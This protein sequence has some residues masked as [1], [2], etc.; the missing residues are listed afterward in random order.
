MERPVPRNDHRVFHR[1]IRLFD[2]IDAETTAFLAAAGA[3]VSLLLSP[4]GKVL[5]VAYRD[6]ALQRYKPDGWIGKPFRDTVTP[7]CH[8]KIDALIEETARAGSTRR[9]Q[10]NHPAQGLP[11]L[12]VDYMVVSID[13]M[14][15]RLAVGED[16]RKLS[17]IQQQLV[18]TQAELESEYRK[19]REAESRYR[20]IFH[21]AAQ[22]IVVVDG[23]DHSIIDINMTG[24][25]ML[26]QQPDKIIGRPAQQLV[27]REDRAT[28]ADALSAA[29]HGGMRKDVTLHVAGRS[30]ALACIVEPYR[31]N[32]R[33]NLMLTMLRAGETDAQVPASAD[34]GL[35]DSFPE[36]LA[37]IDRKGSIRAINDQ[38]L[39]LI[40]V[41]NKSLVVD[42][43]LNNWLGASTVDL[44]VLLS[45]VREEGQVRQFSTVIRDELGTTRTVA[46]SAARVPGGGEGQ[47]IGLLITEASRRDGQF[48]VP[49]P[50]AQNGSSDFAELVGRVPLKDLIREAVDVIEKMCIEA[51]L[52]QT[53]NNR[54][55]AADMLGLSRQ[56]LYIK[57]RRHGLEDFGSES[58]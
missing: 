3:D 23:D 35:L 4:E 36:P 57:L 51:A 30:E 32:G 42:R 37:I 55:S 46:V 8:D 2:D 25:N 22:A 39:D 24:A 48:A 16:M 1:T 53:D 18:R 10:V 33:G 49:T 14:P 17:E 54:A 12:P 58:N 7:E 56:S 5:D 38:F 43:N 19:I 20:T 26:H 11:D 40:H 47:Q 34:T 28:L 45:R 31:E 44:Q 29:R 6:P 15:F 41:L 9:R 50:G 27:Y 21:K 13:K 52:R